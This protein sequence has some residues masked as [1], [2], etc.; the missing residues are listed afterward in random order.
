MKI[1]SGAE[2]LVL[3]EGARTLTLPLTFGRK[4]TTQVTFDEVKSVEV[5][6]IMHSSSKG[7]VSYTYA[8]SLC[9]KNLNSEE[10]LANWPSREK[11]ESFTAWLREK[12]G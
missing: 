6:S 8:P 12:I 10:I 4:Q 3:D 1:Q 7:R 5:K 9:F 2:D 11:A